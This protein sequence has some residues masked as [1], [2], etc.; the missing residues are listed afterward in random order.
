MPNTF[1][2]D[3]V[4]HDGE[5]ISRQGCDLSNVFG[6]KMIDVT[7]TADITSIQI[8]PAHTTI[9][10]KFN[11]TATTNGV[12]AGGNLK[13]GTN[14]VYTADDVLILTSDGTDWYEDTRN[15]N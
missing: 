5:A 1:G 11:A 13:I 7:G 14:F 2:V 10:L 9:M 15:V 3:V 4:G 8:R 12:V 6:V